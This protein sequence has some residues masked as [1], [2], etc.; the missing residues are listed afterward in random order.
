MSLVLIKPLPE[1]PRDAGR[2]DDVLRHA[3]TGMDCRV[4]YNA[5]G[6]TGLQGEKLLFAVALGDSGIN[7]EY[8]R[9][10]QRI[11]RES[12]LFRGCTAGLIVDAAEHLKEVL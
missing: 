10:L 1:Q 7:F 3:L 6:L 5:E 2:M 11:R 12:E 9:M 4:V 8:M